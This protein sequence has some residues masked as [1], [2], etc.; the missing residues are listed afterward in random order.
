M[1][2]QATKGE[3]VQ[4]AAMLS[5]ALTQLE[6]ATQALWQRK[7]EKQHEKQARVH[8]SAR[9][10]PAVAAEVVVRTAVV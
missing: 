1:Q 4:A 9:V 7:R 6:A 5:S 2:A 3:G 10:C 8:L